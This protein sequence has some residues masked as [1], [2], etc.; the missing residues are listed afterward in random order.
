MHR[1]V[2]RLFGAGAATTL[3]FLGGFLH[4]TSFAKNKIAQPQPVAA[5]ARVS[6]EAETQLIN[7]YKLIGAGRSR[8]A[9][10]LAQHLTQNFPNFQLGHL[11]L[12][13]LLLM[14]TKPVTQLG[15]LP[16]HLKKPGNALLLEE[17]REESR[18]RMTSFQDRPP[19][20]TIPSQVLGLSSQTKHVIAVDTERSRLYLLE[21]TANGLKLV[22]DTYIS[23]GK[24]GI[25]KYA[26]GDLKTP[27]GIYYLTAPIDPKL[28]APLYGG[29]ALPIN[30]PNRY[31]QRL[32]RTGSGIWLHGTMPERFSRPVKATDGC[33]VLSNPDLQKL[34]SVVSTKTT[35]VIIASKLQWVRPE[36][37]TG[38]RLQFEAVMGEWRSAKNTG[39]LDR[40]RN[41]YTADFRSYDT[42]F[43][44]WWPRVQQELHQAQQQPFEW[45]NTT[46]LAWHPS[47]NEKTGN[48]MIITYDE[49][50]P[51]RK[52][53]V[54]KRQYWLQIGGQWKIFFEGVIS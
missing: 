5:S 19:E 37:L 40:L 42:P 41:F 7:I 23:V 12:G 16:V 17:L 30:Y 38:E 26:E 25:G 9:L 6:Y 29:G 45:R 21:S 46:L 52:Q 32:G 53:A 43:D 47:S 35:P 4:H 22:M 54:T 27:L 24:E 51:K 2:Y 11:I 15:D 1:Q 14:Q 20:G 50:P 48:V 44:A 31:D 39:Q 18:Q 13:D 10:P 34:M 8:D 49:A 3:F 36:Q 33:V 28:L